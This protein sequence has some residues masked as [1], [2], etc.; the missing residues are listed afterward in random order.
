MKFR[1]R[2]KLNVLGEKEDIEK[3]KRVLDEVR[4]FIEVEG[5][6]EEL[7]GGFQEW[8]IFIRKSQDVTSP[9]SFVKSGKKIAFF[10][11]PKYYPRAEEIVEKFLSQVLNEPGYVWLEAWERV[12]GELEG[13][14]K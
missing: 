5:E 4:G 12:C 7:E 1:V 3:I 13:E 11:N 2:L 9:F 10:I 8:N 6:D 14:E